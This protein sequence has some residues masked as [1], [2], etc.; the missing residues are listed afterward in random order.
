MGNIAQA[1]F[2][3]G[4]TT[5][6]QVAVRAH[7]QAVTYGDLR[8][9][10]AAFA[11]RV[12]DAGIQPGD[13]VLLIAPS[14][15]EFVAAYYGLHAAGATL[16]TLNVMS[17][18]PEIDYVLGDAGVEPGGRVARRTPQPR[19][20]PRQVATCPRGP[21]SLLTGGSGATASRRRSTD[22][23]TTPRSSSTPPA[24]PAARRA[25]SSASAGSR[26]SPAPPASA[27]SSTA[28]SIDRARRSRSSTSTVS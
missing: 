16:I 25:P 18:A 22:L 1:V 19:P 15:P 9:L 14:I 7:G 3:H 8:D 20:Q 27:S 23:T 26:L 24:R 6:D 17:T 10:S 4:S 13:R 5:P 11:T 12:I 21:W 2:E 28:T